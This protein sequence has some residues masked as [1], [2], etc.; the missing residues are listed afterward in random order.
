MKRLSLRKRQKRSMPGVLI[1][2]SCGRSSSSDQANGWTV[3]NSSDGAPVAI[4]ICPECQ[5][6]PPKQR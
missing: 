1:C 3:I 4:Y 6:I 5:F 2:S